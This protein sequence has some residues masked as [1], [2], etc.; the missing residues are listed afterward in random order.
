MTNKCF[1]LV[2]TLFFVCSSYSQN[3]KKWS[4]EAGFGG[5]RMLENR[6]SDGNNYVNEDQGNAYFAS[7][8]YWLSNR[9]ALTGGFTLVQQG[10]FTDYSDDIGLKTVN[11]FGLHAGGKYYFFPTKWIF[12]PYIGASVYTNF[13]NLGELV[14]A[15]DSN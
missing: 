11:M 7:L 14:Q 13:I 10:L 15:G 4:V 1:A 8:D 5:I 2:F 9:L 6:Y 3:E 12:Q